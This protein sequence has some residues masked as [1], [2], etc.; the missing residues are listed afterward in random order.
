MLFAGNDRFAP[1]PDAAVHAFCHCV[2]GRWHQMSVI[3]SAAASLDWLA[4]AHGT[5]AG[6]L[7]ARAERAE[8]ARAPLFL[9]YLGGE[10]TPHNDAHARGVF[11]GLSNEHAADEFRLCGDGRRRVRDGR[12]LRRAACGRHDARRGVVHRRRFE[13]C[14][15]GAVVRECDQPRCNATRTARSVRHSA[16]RGLHAYATDDT[17]AEVCVAPP[18]TETVAPDAAMVDLLAVRLAQYRRLYHALRDEFAAAD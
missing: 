11:F 17:L 4:R 6:V 5:T 14:V 18:V 8:P 10:R 7:A 12:R 2:E 1:N 13:E 9:P 16:R 3:L 15:L